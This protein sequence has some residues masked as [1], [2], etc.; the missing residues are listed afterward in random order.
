MK[1]CGTCEVES[2]LHL[3]VVC[4]SMYGCVRVFVCVTA[5]VSVSVRV[6][7]REGTKKDLERYRQ[8]C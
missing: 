8:D 7:A 2:R 3:T 4:V 6:S 1:G 5:C